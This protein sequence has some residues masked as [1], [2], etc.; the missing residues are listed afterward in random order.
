MKKWLTYGLTC[1]IAGSMLLGGCSNGGNNK[2][3][4]GQGNQEP[5]SNFNQTGF[6]IVKEPIKVSMMG[7]RHALVGEWKSLAFFKEMEEMTN[8]QFDFNTPP[9]ANYAEK[10]N[11]AFASGELPDVFFGGQLTPDDEITYGKQG[12]LIPLEGL[13]EKYAPNI[14]K[15]FDEYP[16]IKKSVTAPDGHIYALPSIN[17][18]PIA[19]LPATWINGN[20]LKKLGITELPHTTDELYELLTAFKEQDP[21]GNGKQDEIP[22]TSINLG[23][24]RSVLLPAFGIVGRAH[25][26][27]DGKVIYG[28]IQPEYKEYVTFMNKL[29]KEKLLDPGTFSQTMEQKSAKGNAGQIGMFTDSLPYLTLGGDAESSIIHPVLPALSSSAD[30]KPMITQGSGMA[31]GTF[32]I[33]NKSKDPEALIR[34]VDYLYS[35]EGEILVHYGKEGDLWE[36]ADAE[37]KLR[38]YR[39]PPEGMNLEEYRGGSITPAVGVAVPMF[40]PDEVEAN[41]KDTMHQYRIKEVDEKLAPYGEP[42]FPEIYLLP[43]ERQQIQG[44]E[45]DLNTYMESME[46]KLVTGEAPLEKWDAFL[47]TIEDMRVDKLLEVYQAAYDRWSGSN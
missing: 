21:N 20:W 12:V 45:T 32:A 27:K 6:P 35:P 13:V 43:E 31:R 23:D 39:N 1:T 22:L 29:W 37:K 26:V 40:T 42:V 28:A 14:Q 16:E 36:W 38:K 30:R 44:I 19:K 4:T 24:I 46:A 18:A 11:L 15:M 5:R 2:P 47:K 9:A 34:W 8:L 25:L 7:A 17:M 41:W 10:K 3:E 33:T